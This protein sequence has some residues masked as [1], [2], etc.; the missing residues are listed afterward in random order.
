MI[1]LIVNSTKLLQI[2]ASRRELSYGISHSDNFIVATNK[3]ISLDKLTTKVL[4]L[5]FLN[6]CESPNANPIFKPL[7]NIMHPKEREVVFFELHNVTITNAK[8]FEMRLLDSPACDVCSE[9]QTTDHIF[10]RCSNA[11]EALK[12][13]NES[14]PLFA[15]TPF[16]KLNIESL[17]KRLLYLNRNKKVDLDLFRIAIT[18]RLNDLNYIS[19]AKINSKEMNIINK[20]TLM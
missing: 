11:T 3:H 18:N 9:V 17:I 16:L 4:R 12:A 19:I 13:F 5:R 8:L 20:I 1:H 2:L 14:A 10:N 7:K 6:G 15:S